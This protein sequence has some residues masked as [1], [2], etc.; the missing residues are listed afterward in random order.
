[1]Y[2]LTAAAACIIAF[3]VMHLWRMHPGI[4][5]YYARGGDE[6]LTVTWVKAMIDDGWYANVSHLGFPSGMSFSD[7][8]VPS[9]VHLIALRLIT[10]VV[11]HPA[12]AVNLYFLLG[13]PL[14]AGVSLYVLRR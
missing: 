5:L 14:V 12:T 13:F 9:L 7:F 2:A 6:L 11:H 10:L 1:M 3:L 4:P 8:P